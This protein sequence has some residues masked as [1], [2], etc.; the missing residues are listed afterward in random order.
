MRNPLHIE[1]LATLIEDQLI[2]PGRGTEVAVRAA[3]A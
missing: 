1:D 2:G 3:F